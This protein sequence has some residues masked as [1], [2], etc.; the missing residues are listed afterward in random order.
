MGSENG[1]ASALD[2][3]ESTEELK[4]R[5]LGS[6]LLLEIKLEFIIMDLNQSRSGCSGI[7]KAH[8]LLREYR[9]LL[10]AGKIMASISWDIEVNILIDYKESGVTI[11]C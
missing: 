9:V 3:H 5:K 10:L 4:K 11:I 6:E 1:Y 7:K 2:V 8:P